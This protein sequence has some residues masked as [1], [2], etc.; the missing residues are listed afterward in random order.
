MK[1][2]KID[3]MITEDVYIKVIDAVESEIKLPENWLHGSKTED[4]TDARYIL[5]DYLSK[6]G[7]SSSQIQSAT[8]LKKSTVNKLLAGISERVA[9]RSITRS[10]WLQIGSKLQCGIWG[11]E[12]P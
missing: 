5:C 11:I 8:G 10:W 6:K 7:L 12:K 3:G 2:R 9:R 4:A 1:Q